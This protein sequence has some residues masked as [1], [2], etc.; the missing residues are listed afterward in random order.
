MSESIGKVG[1]RSSGG[2]RKDVMSLSDVVV[3]HVVPFFHE[4]HAATGGRSISRLDGSSAK[5]HIATYTAETG[6]CCR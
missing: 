5:L 6:R 2:L 1:Q 3:F 4:L